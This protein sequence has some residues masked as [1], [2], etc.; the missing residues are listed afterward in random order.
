MRGDNYQVRSQD[1]TLPISSILKFH[2]NVG[3]VFEFMKENF[4]A[5]NKE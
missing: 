5:L 4:V 1:I 3:V 2:E